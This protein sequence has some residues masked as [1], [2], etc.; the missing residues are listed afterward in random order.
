MDPATG[1]TSQWGSAASSHLFYSFNAASSNLEV[2]YWRDRGKEVDFV[3]RSD[4]RLAAIEVTS[5]R[6]KDAR[7][8]LDAFGKSMRDARRLQVGGQGIP[9]EEFLQSRP[10]D[11]LR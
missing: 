6:R 1:T 3:L 9:L 5:G 11:W 4:R 2:F 7:P 8:G 10:E